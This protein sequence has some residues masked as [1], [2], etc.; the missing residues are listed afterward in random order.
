MGFLE[1]VGLFTIL[2]LACAAIFGL[3][4][5]ITTYYN[6]RL[7]QHPDE[8]YFEIARFGSVHCSTCDA[9]NHRCLFCGH[10][11][12]PLG[13]VDTEGLNQAKSDQKL[14]KL[15][16]ECRPSDFWL[17][18]INSTGI[19]LPGWTIRGNQLKKD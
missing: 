14:L 4:T 12:F 7:G 8:P 3:W 17:D 6:L 16:R 9:W 19:S 13:T 1:I 10:V 15:R 2:V 5:I 11:L 18:K